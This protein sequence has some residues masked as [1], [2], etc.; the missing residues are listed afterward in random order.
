M[1]DTKE[2]E[3]FDNIAVL[4]KFLYIDKNNY[5]DYNNGITI[6][7]ITL[8]DDYEYQ[9]VN[10]NFPNSKPTN[11]SQEMSIPV[12]ESIIDDLKEQKP[13]MKNTM[14]KNRWEEISTITKANITLKKIN[15]RI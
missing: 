13:E 6:L 7:R 2:F 11:F 1:R 15:K 10:L 14:F 3:I 5:I 12:I 9:V 8:N 4:N